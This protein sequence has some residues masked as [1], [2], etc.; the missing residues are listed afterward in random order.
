[1]IAEGV[2]GR[3]IDLITL[4]NVKVFL[5]VIERFE[6]YQEE[7]IKN[8]PLKPLVRLLATRNKSIKTRLMDFILKFDGNS[9]F[10]IQLNSSIF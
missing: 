4:K 2:I 6:G 5:L 3:L 10:G 7:I 1:M 8:V 9:T